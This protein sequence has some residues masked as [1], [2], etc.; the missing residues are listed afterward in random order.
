ML[1]RWLLQGLQRLCAATVRGPRRGT[2]IVQPLPGIGDMVWHLGHIHSIAMAEGAPVTVLTKPRSRAHELFA[3]DGAVA[4]VLWLERNPGRHD[5]VLGFFRLVCML[6][7]RR[8]ARAWLLHGSSRYAGT[9]LLAGIPLTIGYGRGLQRSLLTS[10]TSLPSGITHGHPMRL[11]DD[12]LQAHGIPRREPVPRVVIDANAL[13]RIDEEYHRCETPWIAFGIGSSEACKQWGAPRFARL[14]E[15]LLRAAAGTLFLI[16]GPAEEAIAREITRDL[17]A[18]AGR[19]V[20]VTRRPL[21]E[22]IALLSRCGLCVSNDTG[23]FNAAAATGIP[24]LVLIISGWEP[25]WTGNVVCVRPPSGSND[26]AAIEV[27]AVAAAA[28]DLQRPP[29]RCPTGAERAT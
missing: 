17:P 6:R 13:R 5:G 26:V 22:S 28:A 10:P 20:T 14:A 3:A 19:V 1:M 18:L 23:V 29:E 25:P 8:Y 24:V 2:L 11:A 21:N 7:R 9:L 4:E 27:E 15:R 12:L 16:G